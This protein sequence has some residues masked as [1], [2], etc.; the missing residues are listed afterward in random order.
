MP[1]EVRC[2]A[3]NPMPADFRRRNGVSDEK[4]LSALDYMDPVNFAPFLRGA[5]LMGTGLMDKVAPPEGQY[6]IYNRAVCPKR[7]L[8]YPK[9]EHE[10]IN[11]FENELIKFLHL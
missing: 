10:R 8:V 1:G 3:L 9:Y 7:H 11:F 5:L 4:L 2:A 6:A